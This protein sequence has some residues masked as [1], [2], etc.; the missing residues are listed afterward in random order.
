MIAGKS[1]CGRQESNLYC[2]LR[3]PVSYPLEDGRMHRRTL[4]ERHCSRL[5]LTVHVK[6]RN[7]LFIPP[8]GAGFGV[9]GEAIISGETV[10]ALIS[11]TRKKLTGLWHQCCRQT[12]ARDKSETRRVLTGMKKSSRF[13]SSAGISLFASGFFIPNYK[14]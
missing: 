8:K 4:A 7:I 11:A 5:A 14:L 13:A 6:R 3:R 1:W 2:G 12:H 9:T 10:A